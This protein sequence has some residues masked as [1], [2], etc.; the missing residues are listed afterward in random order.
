MEWNG[1]HDAHVIAWE[2]RKYQ[3]TTK[4]DPKI[5]KFYEKNIL[6]ECPS[7]HEVHM[8][9]IR[10]QGIT[11]ARVFASRCIDSDHHCKSC[12]ISIE[13]I[14]Y[15]PDPEEVKLKRCESEIRKRKK[16]LIK[17]RV[18]VLSSVAEV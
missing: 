14:N 1:Q 8:Y 13:P 12:G 5:R 16:S 15:V 9:I 10:V 18:Y 6:V 11:G 17:N 7:C 3:T 4:P 2:L